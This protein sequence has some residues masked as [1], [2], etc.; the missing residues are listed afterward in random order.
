MRNS[1]ATTSQGLQFA[2]LF[3]G[4]ILI[5]QWLQVRAG[6]HTCAHYYLSIAIHVL[7]LISHMHTRIHI[8]GID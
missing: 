8:V 7:I 1:V 3:K 2:S 6:T 5:L 4:I